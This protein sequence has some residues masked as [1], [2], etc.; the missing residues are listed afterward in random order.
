MGA[1]ALLIQQVQDEQ[2]QRDSSTDCQR[3]PI[4][5]IGGPC[6]Q[7]SEAGPAQD[8]VDR[9]DETG[10]GEQPLPRR[11]PQPYGAQRRLE[12]RVGFWRVEELAGFGDQ[13]AVVAADALHLPKQY[14][15]LEVLRTSAAKVSSS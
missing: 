7:H 15:V 9:S 10:P 1:A 11:D 5:G 14:Q 12:L 4:P 13:A 8:A 2:H 3:R 6:G